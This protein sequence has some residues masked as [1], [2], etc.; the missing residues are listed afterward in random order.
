MDVDG[1]LTDGKIYMGPSGEAMKA[2]SVK[3]GYAINYILKPNNIVSII[4][5]ARTSDIV[6]R[7]CE[8][9]GITE[10]H[11]GKHDKLSALI[12]IVGKENLGSCAYFGDDVLDQKC[13]LPIKEEGGIIGCPSDAVQ[14]VKAISDYVC[15]QKAGEGALR[16]FAEWLTSIEDNDLNNKLQLAVAYLLALTDEQLISGRHEVSEDFFYYVQEYETKPADEWKLESHRKYVDIQI[17]L[18]GAE[19]MDIADISR[20]SLSE[21]YNEDKDVL[22]WNIPSRMASITLRKG[23]YVILY[24]ENAYRGT[25]L[26]NQ[27]VNIRKI[28]GKVKI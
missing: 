25:T 14:E 27:E 13:M 20:L 4:I 6:M 28:V 15:L 9:L 16:E 10:V 1:T 12:E 22:F 2:F 24:P 8:E 19:R 5:T 17:M 7:R 3:D 21:E 11:Q 23:D 18:D 26:I